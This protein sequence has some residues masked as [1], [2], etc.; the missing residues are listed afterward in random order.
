MDSPGFTNA[1]ERWSD[2]DLKTPTVIVQPTNH[3][4]VATLV[5]HE[6]LIGRSEECWS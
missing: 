4:D 5:S 6:A 3:G 2:I 1:L